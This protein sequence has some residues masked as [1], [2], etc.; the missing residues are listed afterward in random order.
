MASATIISHALDSIS[1]VCAGA[2]QLAQPSEGAEEHEL[3]GHLGLEIFAK[4]MWSGS[5]TRRQKP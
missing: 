4:V 2:L 5:P 3:G 1:M